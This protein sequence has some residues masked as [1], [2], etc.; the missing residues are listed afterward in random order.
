MSSSA[1]A[2]LSGVKRDSIRLALALPGAHRYPFEA[3]IVADM[4]QR[5]AALGEF[6]SPTSDVDMWIYTSHAHRLPT[7]RLPDAERWI[8][9]W[10]V[11][12]REPLLSRDAPP[13]NLLTQ[14]TE[15]YELFD[16]EEPGEAIKMITQNLPEGDAPTLVLFLFWGLHTEGPDLADQLD[17]ASG[18]NVFWQFLGDPGLNSSVLGDLDALRAEAPHIRN[19]SVYRGW[20][21]IEETP[22]YLFDRGVLKPFIRWRKERATRGF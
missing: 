1:A 2:R 18:Q 11:L 21:S 12:P 3:G 13:G 5:A 16:S 15:R 14:Y 19:V 6:V 17:S 4:V 10:G 8:A 20:D 9:D 22:G 7:L